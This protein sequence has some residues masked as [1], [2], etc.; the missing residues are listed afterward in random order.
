M[1]EFNGNMYH[2]FYSLYGATWKTERSIEIPIVW[3]FVHKS[4]SEKKKVLEV[5]NVL[6]Y[7]FYT[8]HDVVDKYDKIDNVINEDIVDYNPPYKYDLIVSISTLEHVGY[9]EEVKDSTKIIASIKNLKRLL[10]SNGILVVT[11]PLGQNVEMDRLISKKILVFD[12]ML[13]MRREQGKK[14]KQIAE[15]NPTEVVYNDRIP[16]ANAIIIGISK[17]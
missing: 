12:E 13:Y 6:S 4:Y 1:F 3:K 10:N 8:N 14:W 5:G 11:L 17:C 16:A 9:D 15:I 7:R 2:Y